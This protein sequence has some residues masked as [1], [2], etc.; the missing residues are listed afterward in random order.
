MIAA[1]SAN[2]LAALTLPSRLG[3]L[4][5]AVDAD[6]RRSR[7]AWS[8]SA[9]AAARPGSKCSTLSPRLGDF[10]EDLRRLGLEPSSAML[11]DQLVPADAAR[12]LGPA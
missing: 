8:A 11:R 9:D 5:V 12:F 2:H 4:Y 10:N 1:L 3:R 7:A 6:P